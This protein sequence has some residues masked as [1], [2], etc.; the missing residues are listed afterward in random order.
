MQLEKNQYDITFC[1]H[2]SFAMQ[3]EM[4]TGGLQ[5]SRPACT[6]GLYKQW[7]IYYVSNKYFQEKIDYKWK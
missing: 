5:S 7:K 4:P 1:H 2:Q 6:W 3:I